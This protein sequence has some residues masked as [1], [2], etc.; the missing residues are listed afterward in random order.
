MEFFIRNTVTEDLPSIYQ[1]FENSINY[2]E[3]NGY[4][5]WRNYDRNAIIRDVDEKNQYKIVVGDAIALVFSVGYRDPIIWRE[6][7]NGESIYLHRI[8]INPSFKGQRLFGT[9]LDWSKGHIKNKNLKTIRMDTWASN[10]TI[11]NYYKTF[12]FEVIENFTTPNTIALPAHNR[13]LALT[14][15]EYRTS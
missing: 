8:V 4:P 7:D 12:G 10:P 9:V 3:K 2:Q 14:L 11:I 13:N 1:L 5:A 15:L 6:H